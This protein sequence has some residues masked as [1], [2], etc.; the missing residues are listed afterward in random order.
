M[1][2]LKRMKKINK[3][4]RSKMIKI[5]DTS[6][7][8]TGNAYVAFGWEA[9][10]SRPNC[11]PYTGMLRMNNET[12]QAYTSD[13]HIKRHVRR[14][15]K[16]YAL[17][18]NISKTDECIFYEKQD[19]FGDSVEFKK[20]LDVVRKANAISKTDKKDALN[21]CIDLPLF[22]YV[23]AVE[24]ESFNVNGA[25]NTLFRPSTIH[26]CNTLSFGRNNAFP[27]SNKDTDETN[28]SA[29][30]ASVDILEYGMFVSLWEI[31]LNMLRINTEGHKTI[32]WKDSGF[33]KWFEM[34]INGMWKAYT[35][36][37]YP[38]FTQRAQFAQ[39]LVAWKP[40]D[41]EVSYD[42]PEDIYKKL[43]NKEITNH[44]D[45]VVAINK[46]LPEFFKGWDCSDKTI[47]AK[48]CAKNCN[49]QYLD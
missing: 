11:D 49:I 17:E 44:D 20:R 2:I 15:M 5:Q 35:T 8:K 37:R 18:N 7:M 24:K 39:F 48:A 36:E 6:K 3:K 29:G 12:Q 47:F 25:M 38:S 26:S 9:I 45:A 23:H 40:N 32:S 46:H 14:G 22:G 43:D 28:S 41:S 4:R 1:T 31:N 21:Y 30:S 19:K 33:E 10:Q 16:A 34:V 42:N 27:G 13:V